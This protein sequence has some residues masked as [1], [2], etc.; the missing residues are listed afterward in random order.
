[1]S[2]FPLRKQGGK[3][4]SERE[5]QILPKIHCTGRIRS[6]INFFLYTFLYSKHFNKK[7]RKTNIFENSTSLTNTNSV[8]Y[9]SS[10]ISRAGENNRH[11]R[12]HCSSL[13]FFI[14]L[15]YRIQ[16]S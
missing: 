7:I 12:L 4:D 10:T 16:D 5:V 6:D 9:P 11:T 13:S 3:K 8:Q 15:Q 1:M 14:I 2:S